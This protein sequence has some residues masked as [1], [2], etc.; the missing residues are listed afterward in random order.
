M[1]ITEPV[2]KAPHTPSYE[3]LSLDEERAAVQVLLDSSPEVI[4]LTDGPR[5]A[6][7]VINNDSE[8]SNLARSVEAEVFSEYFG[9]D[10]QLMA[11]EYGP[12][13]DASTFFLVVDTEDKRRAGVMRILRNSSLGFKATNDVSAMGITDLEPRQ[14]LEN[15]GVKSEETT[16]EIA[17]IAAAPDYRGEKTNSLISAAMYRALHKYCHANGYTDLIAIIDAKPLQ[18]LHDI[19]LPVRTSP[20]VQSPFAYLDAKANSLIHIPVYE[21]EASMQAHDQD[22]YDFLL[23]DAGFDALCTLSFVEK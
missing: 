11:E 18:N 22:T 15:I 14:V 6:L 2:P 5:Y 9:N 7:M 12:Y 4:T 21:V 23:G 20:H 16:L 3:H 1:T 13:E 10:P 19:H 17:T 8:F